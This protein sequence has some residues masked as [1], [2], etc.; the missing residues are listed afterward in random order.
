MPSSNRETADALA[1][2]DATADVQ[3]EASKLPI[4]AGVSSLRVMSSAGNIRMPVDLS[5]QTSTGLHRGVHMSR[6]V[7]AANGRRP[8][9]MEQWLRWICTDVNKTQPGS[10]VT[11]TF[12]LPYEDQFA[13]VTMRA[14]ARGSVTYRYIVDGMTACPCSKKMIGIGHMQRA[15][16][17]VIMKS[18]RPLDSL[19]VVGRIAECFSASPKEEMKRLEEAKKILLAQ[20]NP[21]FAEDLVRD[22]VSRFP[23]ALFVSGRCLESIHAHDA[24]ATW[25]ARPGWMPLL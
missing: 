14:T 3:S 25:S 18:E 19:E 5:I 16:M 7:K 23:N 8:R 11:A 9:G 21:K 4:D 12:E 6:L 20:A 17:T 1:Y 22:C 2:I 13:K 15:Q 10:S 24:L